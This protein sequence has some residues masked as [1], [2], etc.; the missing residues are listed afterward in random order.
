MNIV[1]MFPTATEAACAKAIP[2]ITP[3]ISGIGLRETAYRTTKVIQTYR[4]DWLVMAGIAGVY[5]HSSLQVGDL[6]LVEQEIE[7]DIGFYSAEGFTHL[8]RLAIDMEF[9]A[10]ECWSCP[11]VS[12]DYG[13]P[14]AVSN[15]MNCAMAPFVSTHGV[16]I[17]NM[18][19]AAF[20]QV[21]LA[22][23]QPFLQ[24]RSISNRVTFEDEPWD[25]QKSL[26]SLTNGLIRLI[27]Q[28]RNG[29]CP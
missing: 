14:L 6:C 26:D 28:L 23:K 1:V 5:G 2:H 24:L 22:E 3:V 16:D 27:E 15:S 7:A 11:Y 12:V 8:T 13:F 10:Q 4:P 21:C 17:E 25:M 29:V 18:E 9:Q 20:F 19:G